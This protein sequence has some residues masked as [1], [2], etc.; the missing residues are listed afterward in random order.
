MGAAAKFDVPTFQA[1]DLANTQA[2]LHRDLEQSA[3]PPASPCARVGSTKNCCRFF[4]I[5]EFNQSAHM[6]LGGNRQHTLTGKCVCRFSKRHVAEEAAY[7]S[8]TSVA[9]P[10]GV[11][12]VFFQ[13]VEKSGQKRCIQILEA[14]IGWCTAEMCFDEAQQ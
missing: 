6:T 2:G 12:T 4:R 13:V 3:V 5:E 9:G 14:K 10:R 11:A 8:K 1:S 7:G